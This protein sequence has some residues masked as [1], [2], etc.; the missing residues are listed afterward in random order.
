M[1][2]KYNRK[3]PERGK[4]RYKRRLQA[5]GLRHA[6]ALESVDRLRDRQGAG[7]GQAG[8]EQ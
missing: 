4:S 3:H 8:G 5:R 2:G 7:R 1:A 6:P